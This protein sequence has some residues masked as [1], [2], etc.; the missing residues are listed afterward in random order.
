MQFDQLN[1]DRNPRVHTLSGKG[2]EKKTG[3]VSTNRNYVNN[4]FYVV[5][6]PLVE[7]ACHHFCSWL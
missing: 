4:L 7:V 5:F 6:G 2:Q 1:V 3:K